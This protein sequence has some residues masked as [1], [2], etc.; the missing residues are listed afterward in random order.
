MGE[1][2]KYVIKYLKKIILGGFF[3]Y[4]YNVIAVTFN[5]TIPIN[6]FTIIIVGI[7]DFSGLITLVL[8]K[9]IGL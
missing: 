3:I 7:F 2:M 6:L 1:V 9:T 5:L 8:L 4:A